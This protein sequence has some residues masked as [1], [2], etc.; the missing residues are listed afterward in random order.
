MI[1]LDG[2]VIAI[3]SAD[4]FL[5]SGLSLALAD[6][7]ASM[8]L[9]VEDLAEGERLAL[10]IA[11]R[12]GVARPIECDLRDPAAVHAA[13]DGV[14]G[15]L[16]SLGAVVHNATGGRA[17]TYKE[18]LADLDPASWEE[19]CAVG[20]R[21]CYWLAEA[22]HAHLAASKGSYT[23]ITSN[24]GIEGDE[25]IPLFSTIKG[26][27]RGFLKALAREWGPDGI[28]VNCLGPIAMSD[29]MRGAMERD[30]G[31]YD[32][33][34]PQIALRRWGD[35]ITDIGPALAFLCSREAGYITGQTL[36]VNG[37]RYTAL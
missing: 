15:T 29:E 23:M 34:T 19:Q 8:A 9:L 18:Q 37:G 21:S 3:T 28:R 25:D 2:L 7:G 12:G 14:V 26:A 30:P 24:D 5:G 22:C 32:R 6:A 4:G 16:G 35:P 1:T 36:L 31:L 11:A 17:N 20:L 27:Q 33:I 13:I 10:E